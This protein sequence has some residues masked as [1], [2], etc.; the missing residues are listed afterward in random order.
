[1]PDARYASQFWTSM[2]NTFKDNRIIFDLF[3]EPYPDAAASW[4]ST[5]AWKC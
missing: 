2:A 5:A 1:M 4:D 3:N